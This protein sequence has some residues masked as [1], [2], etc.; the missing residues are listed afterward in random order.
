[1][2]KVALCNFQK[3]CPKRT[4]AQHVEKIFAQSGHPA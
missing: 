3:T 4:I 1:M 2:E